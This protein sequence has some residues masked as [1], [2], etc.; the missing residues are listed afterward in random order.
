MKKFVTAFSLLLWLTS[1]YAVETGEDLLEAD[2]AFSLSTRVVNDSTL[3]ASWK[4][5]PG[6]YMYRDKFKFEALDGALVKKPI[7]PHGKIKQDPLFGATETYIKSVKVR[8]PIERQGNTQSLRLKITAQGCN[9]PVG[10]CYP[11]IVKQVDFKLPAVKTAL[12]KTTDIAPA[13][14]P[15]SIQSLK[16]LTASSAA[17]DAQPVDPE[18]AFRINMEARATD[19]LLARVDIADCCYLYRDKIKFELSAADG[20][21][22]PDSLRLNSYSLPAG[23][24]K[25]DEFIGKTE[26]YEK[27][28]EVP[29]TIAGLGAQNKN[30]LL[31]VGYQGCS[32]KG[33]L[34]C[35]PPTVK[36]FSVQWRDGVL[37][38]TET[39]NAPVA[40]TSSTQAPRDYAKLLIAI[41]T[42][43][44]TGLLLTFTP[45]VLPMIPIL[46]SII[47]GQGDVKI[48]KLRGGM[49]SSVYVLGTAVTY[50]V[51][52]VIAGATG[53]QLQ[54]YF[55]NAWAIGIFS[56]LFILLALSMFGFYELQMPSF[57]QSR[58][59][60]STQSV[61]GGSFF[62]VFIL[63]LISAL[64]VGA[65]VSPLL[66]SALGA[67]ILSRDPVLGGAVMFSM[68][69]GMG[70]ILIAIGVGAGF[71]LPRA[72][73]WMDR[74]KQVFGVLLLAVAIS[75]LGLLPQVPVLF[76]W[77]AL[78]IITGV[79]LSATQSLP[80]N[81]SGWRFLWKGIGTFLLI[82]GVLA[83]LGGFAGQRDVFHPL[84]LASVAS[85]VMNTTNARPAETEI[86]F[87]R[88]SSL[89]QLQDRLAAAKSAGKPVIVDYYATWC[90]DCLRMEQGTFADP[91]VREQ[92]KRFVRLQPDVTNTGDADV[93]AMKKH[94]R[95]YGPPAIVLLNAQGEQYG[96]M[97][98][99]GFHGVDE[100]LN[101]LNK[102]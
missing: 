29:L 99:Y 26:V 81:A 6:Y 24:I 89:R 72:G 44:G 38:V 28:F 52:G 98:M 55:Q 14:Q 37:S 60:T 50:T 16:D 25:T 95:I 9:E 92:L 48:T 23:K 91:R 96:E 3:E 17:G 87:E 7:F 74:V 76:L 35:Y 5:A 102:I 22:L 58:L 34:I 31:Q 84:P 61:K 100:M 8:L 73:M 21:A 12:A 43:F 77:A 79:F 68:S 47:V 56:A 11:P 83:L 49:L 30:L 15:S 46:S 63:G 10:V 51:A 1:V 32:E 27:S 93:E 67:A 36:K 57:I 18:I 88:L 70:A 97:P 33:V 82:W 19:G 4:I 65:C 39:A 62:G 54:A 90:T 75:F 66:I 86:L 53:E 80:D 13:P 78:F 41:V 20:G 101:L 71:L 2:Q 94:F 85:S 69:L 64:I 45:C 40:P 42:A 59:Q